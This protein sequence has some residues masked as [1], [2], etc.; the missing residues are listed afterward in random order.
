MGGKAMKR[1]WRMRRLMGV[2]ALTL[3]VVGCAE[4]EVILSG[5]RED[6]RSPGYDVSDATA[7]ANAA[8]VA[9]EA[10][11]PFT[12]LSRPANVGAGSG[13]ARWT[14]R[15]G[16]AAHR[17]PHAAFSAR[18]QL[19]WS[20]DAGAGNERKFRITAEPVS[21]GTR[22]F[23]MDSH[24]QLVAHGIGGEDLWTV[25]LTRPGERAGSGSGGGLALGAGKLFA[26]TNQG[27]LIALDPATGQIAWR[28]KF[29]GGI[30]GAPTV[31]GGRI[32]VSTANSMGYAV[33]AGNGRIVW[34]LAGVPTQSGVSG[35]AAPAV[36]G[37]I[38]VFPLANGSLLG[39]DA[40]DGGL[41]WVARA[42]GGRAGSGHSVLQAFT[43][44]PVIA[45]GVVYAATAA[46][47]AI[48]VS[49]ATGQKLWTVEEGAQG[50]MAVAGGSVYF[51]TDEAR[52]VRLSARDG[53]KVWSVD[54]PRYTK[55][56]KPRRLKSVWPAFGPLLAGGRLW[57]A[58][59][60][61]LLRAFNPAD[62]AAGTTVELPSGAASRPIVVGGM[63]MFMTDKGDL[64][65]L[66]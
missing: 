56:D 63:M 14:H 6:L 16:D 53:A 24:A 1:L 41:K 18:P 45:G 23:T 19:V 48:A 35:A 13:V 25:D 7:A 40:G 52:L 3:L 60:D 2:S 62:G 50:T 39:V 32:Y 8:A 22:V 10:N 37:N 26:T 33:N 66:R 61:G 4:K 47:R 31:A 29:P 38:V 12:N 54:L 64:I 58:S 43:G 17:L 44:E 15:G 27:E 55:P 28:Q 36:S 65:G 30:H 34:D 5:L 42:S 21:D 59:G 49:L 57:I 11:A 51:V 20:S 9:A 46:G